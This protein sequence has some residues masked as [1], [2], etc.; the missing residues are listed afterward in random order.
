MLDIQPGLHVVLSETQG[1][2]VTRHVHS[3]R[4]IHAHKDASNNWEWPL[5]D[6]LGSVREVVDNSVGVLE[7]RNYDPFGTGFG[8]TGTSQTGYGFTGEQTDGT[9]FL[10]LRNRFMSPI[11][12]QFIS[13]DFLESLNRYAYVSGN[14]IN[15]VDLNGLQNFCPDPVTGLMTLCDAPPVTVIAPP[16]PPIT[17]IPNPGTIPPG[18]PTVGVPITIT[19]KPTQTPTAPPTVGPTLGPTPTATVTAVPTAPTA[20]ATPQP[21]G[22]SAPQP[23]PQ[24]TMCGVPTP[25]VTATQTQKPCNSQSFSA[26]WLSLPDQQPIHID[27]IDFAWENSIA[28]NS[29]DT[30][31]RNFPKRIDIPGSK[32]LGLRYDTIDADGASWKT[33]RLI[34]AKHQTGNYPNSDA[35]YIYQS[36][37]DLWR[38]LSRYKRAVDLT[39]AVGLEIRT[40]SLQAVPFWIAA[41]QSANFTYNVNGFVEVYFGP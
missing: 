35:D 31:P 38:E 37:S 18:V 23:A 17:W 41:L 15:F 36:G 10:Y 19:P 39:P 6:G 13:Q 7:S 26:W 14:P 8:N 3:L 21:T 24:P 33:C 20:T 25:V 5:Q 27:P 1:A 9:G 4:G 16:L 30:F 28:R 22:T 12:G 32:A 34:D 40:N 2:A 11:I 29:W